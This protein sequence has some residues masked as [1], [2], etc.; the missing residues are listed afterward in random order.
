MHSGS[1]QEKQYGAGATRRRDAR[2][3]AESRFPTALMGAPAPGLGRDGTAY[4][5]GTARAVWGRATEQYH[6]QQSGW[7]AGVAV[8]PFLAFAVAY[9]I[10][11]YPQTDGD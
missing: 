2:T 7:I 4:P 11:C 8:R 9:D 1:T 5:R 6:Y 10:A 3:R